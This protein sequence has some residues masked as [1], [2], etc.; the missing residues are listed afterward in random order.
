MYNAHHTYYTCITHTHT[1]TYIHT[2]LVCCSRAKA[3]SVSGILSV[4][5]QIAWLLRSWQ[6]TCLPALCISWRLFRSLFCANGTVARLLGGSV[7]VFCE[8][9]WI[10]DNYANIWMC[11]YVCACTNG[12]GTYCCG[13]VLF[14]VSSDFVILLVC[15]KLCMHPCCVCV[16]VMQVCMKVK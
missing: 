14:A 3:V 11:M 13:S 16:C 5:G 2:Y 15:K 9:T 12:I 8:W 1:H 7:F 6:G 10:Y 4:F